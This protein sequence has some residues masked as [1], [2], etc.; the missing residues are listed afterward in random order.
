VNSAG[1]LHRELVANADPGQW[2]REIS[3]N[4]FGLMN[5]TRVA[6]TA[7]LEQGAGHIVNVSSMNARKFPLGGSGYS[8]SKAGV[9][10]FTETLRQ[11]VTEEGIRTTVIE[12]GRVDTVMQ[13]EET[14]EAMRL[15]DP[16][17]VADTIV[18]VVSRPEHVN[19]NNILLRP[20]EQQY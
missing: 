10:A 6:V 5:T 13:D 2:Q 12:P 16:A 15:L 7:M 20:T 11:E 14:R 9:N 1:V 8:A 3:V 4:L 18:Y 17:D 19:V